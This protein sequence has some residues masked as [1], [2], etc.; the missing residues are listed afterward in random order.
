MLY[1]S[2]R[3]RGIKVRDTF[4]DFFVS[5]HDHTHWPSS[6]V[7]PHD[8]PTIL[9]A[10]A[11]MNQVGLRPACFSLLSLCARVMLSMRAAVQ[12][13]FSGHGGSFHAHGD[14]EARLQLAKV[15]PRWWQAQRFGGRREGCV[16]SHLL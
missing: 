13:H 11:G 14:F 3:N 6:S 10:N 9:F 5:K 8:D 7:V 15:H 1:P 16:P 4:I 12:A 2:V